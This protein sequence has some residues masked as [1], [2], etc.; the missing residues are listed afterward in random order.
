MG[1]PAVAAGQ[2][3]QLV[4]RAHLDPGQVFDVAESPA[5]QLLHD[6]VQMQLV[7]PDEDEP[8]W[9]QLGYWHLG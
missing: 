4:A 9:T 5:V 8:H 6:G 1:A 7:R 2:R 3:Y